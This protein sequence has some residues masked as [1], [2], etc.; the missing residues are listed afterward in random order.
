MADCMG[1]ICV[2][3][4]RV[5]LAVRAAP[6]AISPL[7]PSADADDYIQEGGPAELLGAAVD[8]GGKLLLWAVS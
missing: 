6:W 1:G 7:A 5:L 2:T 3:S 8:A 4:K